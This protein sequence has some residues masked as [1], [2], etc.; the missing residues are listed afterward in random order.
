[1]ALDS[2]L[3][4]FTWMTGLVPD[5]SSY[6]WNPMDCGITSGLV[7]FTEPDLNLH[8]GMMNDSR[9]GFGPD[10]T[11]FASLPAASN[12]VKSSCKGTVDASLNTSYSSVRE[13]NSVDSVPVIVGIAFSI[14]SP[15]SPPLPG[16]YR[17][18]FIGVDPVIV[19]PLTRDPSA[20]PP[21][22]VVSPAAV[23]AVP[24]IV[25]I[26]ASENANK[27]FGVG[28]DAAARPVD[29][30]SVCPSTVT[31]SCAIWLSLQENSQSVTLTP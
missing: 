18:T 12:L 22:T 10:A 24:P 23:D 3:T 9:Y 16:P 14:G 28:Y 11:P 21:A 26:D 19:T 27:P 2:L 20:E 25:M 13:K 30:S 7:I 4:S 15:F 31:F 6:A 17:S 5:P 29:V 8:A 1:M